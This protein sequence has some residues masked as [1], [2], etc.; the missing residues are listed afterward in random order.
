MTPLGLFTYLTLSTCLSAL[1]AQD[2][3]AHTLLERA[4][5]DLPDLCLIQ[6]QRLEKINVNAL[7]DDKFI[8]SYEVKFCSTAVRNTC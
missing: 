1:L 5:K 2:W 7:K 3:T 8:R 4:H 6:A